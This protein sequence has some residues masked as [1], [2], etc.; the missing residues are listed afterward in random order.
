[1][2]TKLNLSNFAKVVRFLRNELSK[3]LPT[4]QLDL[5]LTIAEQEGVT[6]NE[7]MAQL[8]MPQGT[9]SRNIKALGRYVVDGDGGDKVVA[10][11]DL[12]R[13][14]PDIYNRKTNA[15]YLT[16]KGQELVAIIERLLAGLSPIGE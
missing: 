15:Y 7:L 8:D 1:M 4:Q 14:E 2:N 9:V 12:I 5:F 13:I 6:T 3:E 16:K 11:Y 10:G